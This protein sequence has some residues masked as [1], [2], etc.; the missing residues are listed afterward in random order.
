MWCKI[1]LAGGPVAQRWQRTAGA[2]R[3]LAG[4]VLT[5][6]RMSLNFVLLINANCSI[7]AWGCGWHD[8]QQALGARARLGCK[9]SRSMQ[10]LKAVVG[11]SA[12]LA[13]CK[14]LWKHGTCDNTGRALCLPANGT[15]GGHAAGNETIP[16]VCVAWH[17]CVCMCTRENWMRLCVI[18]HVCASVCECVCMCMYV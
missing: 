2:R 7:K 9:R 1:C 14:K 6:T 3:W 4:W 10:L 5:H 15:A 16:C 17:D 18:V 12:S 11:S 13:S 8:L